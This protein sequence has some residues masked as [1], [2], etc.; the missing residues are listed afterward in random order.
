[1]TITRVLVVDDDEGVRNMVRKGLQ[2]AGFEVVT[3]ANVSD[4]LWHIAT[5]KFDVL[6]SDLNMPLP[7]DRRYQSYARCMPREADSGSSRF[8]PQSTLTAVKEHTPTSATM[9]SD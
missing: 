9:S 7:G 2:R 5:Q 1:M 3:A 8:S 4:A 6:L